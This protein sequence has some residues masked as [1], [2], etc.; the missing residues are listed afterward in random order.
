MSEAVD[1]N[2]RAVAE[3]VEQETGFPRE[4]VQPN[5]TLLADIGLD[6]E[7]AERF[8]LVF[9]KRFGVALSGLNLGQHFGGCRVCPSRS[10]SSSRS[11]RSRV[12]DRLG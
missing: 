10:A 9:G 1:I 5:T 11:L 4:R 12:L 3:F 7:D 2:F 6:G 8:F